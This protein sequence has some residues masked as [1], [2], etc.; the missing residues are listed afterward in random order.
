[1]SAPILKS[2]TWVL[3]ECNMIIDVRSP[4]EF[5]NDHI[6]GAVNLPVLSDTE[7][8]EIG[9]LYKQES[10]FVARKK[11]AALVA[12]NIAN[13]LDKTMYKM[14]SNLIPLIYCWRGGQRSR[15]FAQICSEIG[16]KSYILNG[17]YKTYRRSV[18][19]RLK[20]IPDNLK[21]IV[22]A[23]RTGS[24]K[25][26]V[27]CA[28]SKKGAQVLDLENLASHRGSLLGRIKNKEQPSQ[29]FFESKLHSQLSKFDPSLNIYVESE[30]SRIGDVQIPGDMWKKIIAAPMISIT[31]PSDE[32]AAY[33]LRGY[34]N[35][36]ND[37]SELNNFIAGMTYRHGKVRAAIWENF[38]Q[39]KSWKPLVE[40][41]LR[42]HYD[43][44]YDKSILRRDRKVLTEISQ[45]NC[46]K[47]CVEATTNKIL[48]LHKM[49]NKTD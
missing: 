9:T 31:T 38:I 21:L 28:L 19:E 17:G 7:R 11:G 43:P 18:I 45:K 24:A 26:D 15:A 5:I 32:R 49:N 27:L 47:L 3:P 2:E 6:P 20:K 42:S 36:T 16:W 14:E 40:D 41:L 39:D 44:A 46:S 33:L 4:S 10:S 29:R 12:R 35:L 1:M 23:G 34:K 37:L 48:S 25:T 22:V 30:S 8:A 13:H